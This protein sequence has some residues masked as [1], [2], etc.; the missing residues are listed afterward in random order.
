MDVWYVRTQ[1]IVTYV[2]TQLICM[3]MKMDH[4]VVLINVQVTTLQMRTEFVSLIH[5]HPH[6]ILINT[7]M[8]VTTA[9]IVT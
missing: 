5:L 6:A 9:K 4:L 8:K 1:L 2:M 3:I 7:W